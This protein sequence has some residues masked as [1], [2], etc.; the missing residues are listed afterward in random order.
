MIVT[1]DRDVL[2]NALI[3]AM[4]TV[5]GKN[6]MPTVE[7]VHL[8]C[9]EDEGKC[10]IET[11]D[12]EKGMRTFVDCKIEKTGSCI[13]NAQKLLMLL[14][15][16]PEGEVKISVDSAYNTVIES[17]LSHF[18]IK[19][20][21]GNQFPSLPELRGD[22]GFTFPQ[23]LFKKFVTRILFA[24]GR[25]NARPFFNGAYFQ[26]TGTQFKV[27][28]CD[29]NRLAI[30]EHN[31]EI[32]NK[33]VFGEALNLKFIVPGKTLVEIL[34]MV[35]DTEDEIEIRLTL[36]YVIFKIGQYTFFSK[37]IDSSY[38]DYTRLIPKQS[39][40]EFNCEASELRGALERSLLIIEDRLA[41]TFRPY[42]K[43]TIDEV[44]SI[45]T[46]SQNGNAFDEIDIEKISGESLTIAFECRS[47]IEAIKVCDDGPMNLKFV[48]PVTGV[49]IEP[50]KA[51]EGK[52]L[53]YIMPMRMTR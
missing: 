3:P 22:R 10:M 9:R 13:I 2:V 36:K 11:Y 29:G 42:V 33:N 21:P 8:V 4:H 26:I 40:L 32:E 44:L 38:F 25:D 50:S 28:S 49:I 39:E 18:D 31:I 51:D 15:A 6:T 20:M 16:M 53:Y 19:C 41:N 23:Y 48:N 47:I 17:G 30:C 52:F 35:K 24:V 5:A 27:V 14:K 45:S 1:F 7:G 34:K 37:T 12:F 43:F 46:Q